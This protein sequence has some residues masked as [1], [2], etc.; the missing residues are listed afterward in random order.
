MLHSDLEPCP[1]AALPA[2]GCSCGGLVGALRPPYWGRKRA[3]G[4]V[5]TALL[6]ASPELS[7]AFFSLQI[8][9][10]SS[11]P[12]T[13]V[14]SPALSLLSSGCRDVTAWGVHM[15]WAELVPQVELGWLWG[16]IWEHGEVGSAR[17]CRADPCFASPQGPPGGGG[18]P[19]TPI[20]P[21]PA[22]T[23]P[24]R[25]PHLWG[26]LSWAPKPLNL[27]WPGDPSPLGLHL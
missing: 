8:P 7:V 22:G 21:S 15:V 27:P 19:G 20:M 18:P 5:S 11:S 13:Y 10:S 12:G 3:E 9:Y 16:L 14:V 1:C 6:W 26:Q 23:T 4:S 24:L 17:A 25:P 2:A